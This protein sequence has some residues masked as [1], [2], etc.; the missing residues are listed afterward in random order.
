[1]ALAIDTITDAG[2]QEVVTVETSTK[3]YLANGMIAHNCED[4]DLHRRLLLAGCGSRVFS[5]NYPFLHYA[6][7]TLKAM[8]PEKRANLERRIG[9]SRAYYQ[10]KWGGN[11]NEERFLRPFDEASA[12]EDGSATT[13]WLQFH[14]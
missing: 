10:K 14:A 6:S 2:V 11:C 3:T 1:M 5:L 13:P 9:H 8:T 12:V 7:G 4:L